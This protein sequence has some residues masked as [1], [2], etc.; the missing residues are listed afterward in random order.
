MVFCLSVVGLSKKLSRNKTI[1]PFKLV[2]NRKSLC[3]VAKMG[4]WSTEKEK[5]LKMNKEEKRK[6]LNSSGRRYQ[7]I[8]NIPTWT[9]YF[10]NKS[11][12]PQKIDILGGYQIDVSKN[13][14]LAGKISIFKGDITTLEVHNLTLF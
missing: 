9:E 1:N 13:K 10:K 2:N 4:D 14:E 3:L 8:E 6:F 11:P 7:T 5:Y 12:L